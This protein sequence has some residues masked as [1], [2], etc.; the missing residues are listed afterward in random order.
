MMIEPTVT[1]TE[2]LG[3][4]VSILIFAAVSAGILLIGLIYKLLEIV[5][6]WCHIPDVDDE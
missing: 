2:L 1:S 6:K 5:L 3:S 4:A